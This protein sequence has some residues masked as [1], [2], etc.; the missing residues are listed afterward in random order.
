NGVDRHVESGLGDKVAYFG[1][2]EAEGE[3]LEITY[4]DLQR[5]VVKAANGFRSIGIR[6]GTHVGVYLGMIPELPVTMLA[7]AR[8]GAPFTVVFGGFS[9]ESLSG[10][11]ND[12][13]CEYLVTQDEGWRGG[14]RV[15]L[16][17]NA[18]EALDQSPTVKT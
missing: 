17:R 12:M 16:K 5:R 9:A 3:R 18:D 6:K 4:V 15:P 1:E 2:G 10:R 13:Q 8:I 7:L 11:M 14:N